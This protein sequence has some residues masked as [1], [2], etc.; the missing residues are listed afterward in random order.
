MQSSNSSANGSTKAV[1]KGYNGESEGFDFKYLVAKVAGN[2]QWFALSLILCLGLGI[3]Y[4]IYAI[5]TF[6]ITSRIMVNGNNA[7]K[8][9]SGVT[10]TQ[11]LSELALFSQQSDVNNEIQMLHSR[12]LIEQTIRDLQTNV[13]YWAQG[14]IRFSEVYLKSSFLI[15][16][17]DLKKN[18]EDPLAWDIRIDGDQVKFIDD[19]TGDKFTLTWGD[20]AK[21]KFCTFVLLKNPNV[22]EE[23]DPNR[24]LG[25]KIAPFDATYYTYN[26][27]LLTFLSAENTTSIDVT[28]DASVPAKGED[29]VNHLIQLY[30]QTKI[31]NSNAIADSTIRFIDER[32]NGV[33]RELTSVEQ[34]LESIKQSGGITDMQE[35]AKSLLGES[36]DAQKMLNAQQ[37]QIEWVESL[38]TQ[39]QSETRTMPTTSPITDQAYITMVEKYNNLQ[40]QRQTLLLNSTENNP[41]VKGIDAQLASMRATLRNTLRTYKEGLIMNRN[42]L[43]QQTANVQTR[44]QSL[45]T[46]QRQYLEASRRQDVLQQLYVYLLTVREQTAVTKSNNI[47][48]IRIVD[49]AKAGVYP[50]WPIKP[51]IIIVC[52]F[53]GV[54]IPAVVLLV[55]ELNNTKVT[56]P[57]DIIGSTA[58]PFIGEISQSKSSSPV[59]VTRESRTAVAEQFRTLRTDLLFRLAGTENKVI[60]CTSTVS[61]E[62]KSFVTL[63]LAAALALSGKKVLLVDLELRKMQLSKDLGIANNLGIADYLEKNAPLAEVILPSGV[64]ENLWCLC[65]GQLQAN[66][67]EALLNDRMKTMFDDMRKKFDYIV[68]D[69]PPAAIVT[70]AQMIGVYADLTLYVVRQL[71]TYKKHIDVIEDLRV[72]NKLNNIF[73]IMNDVKPVP[74]YNKGYGFGYRF[75]EDYGYYQEEE[76]VEKKPLLQRIFPDTES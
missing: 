62:G 11:M 60:M 32:I 2:W 30:V 15:E 59:V 57:A 12:T 17:I 53:L 31:N 13:S 26:E 67:S 50:S 10:E 71:Y 6:T 4:L 33:A 35:V 64:N 72:N 52:L 66:P 25:L 29:F 61:G 3:I 38:E 5:P 63:N 1:L 68:V 7:N 75:D 76:K 46:R 73:V 69:T 41:Q 55:N 70:D 48:P 18:L 43:Q 49:V 16:L 40:Q 47:A 39:L 9:S 56:T 42:N 23:T 54:V 20:T 22:P 8:T 74:G 14:D 34:G 21:L 28:L 44:I 65:S 24:P 51:I 36:A 19:F 45:P 27:N 58:A 37:A